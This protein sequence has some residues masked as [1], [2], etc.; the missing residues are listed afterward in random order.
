[1]VSARLMRA[2][3]IAAVVTQAGISV[4]GSVVRVTGSGL[5]CPDWPTCFPG[6]MFPDPHED[7]AWIHQWVEFGNRLLV[8]LVSAVAIACLIGALGTRRRG[9]AVGGAGEQSRRRLILLAAAMPAGVAAQAVIGGFT[10]LLGLAWWTVSVHFLVSMVLVWLAVLLVDAST[11]AV[12]DPAEPADTPAPVRRLVTAGSVTLA[13]LLVAGTMVTA[14]GPHAGDAATPRLGL[15]V[16]LM[17]QIHGALLI[18]YL[19]LL[20][21]L[22]ARLRGS[23][24]RVRR[25]YRLLLGAVL[26]Q[27]LLGVVQY[28]LGVPE[29]LVSLHVL[30]ACL[31]AAAAAALWAAT[32][33]RPGVPAR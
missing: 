8:G 14:A 30:G 22:G 19:G 17:A 9:K 15:G 18:V 23:T 3:A 16:P 4:T 25:A 5:G 12:R 13:A 11:D 27:G 26:A 2:L 10:V 28:R 7:I 32:H 29:I 6:R 33:P 1:M 20:A 24:H 31:V 21:G